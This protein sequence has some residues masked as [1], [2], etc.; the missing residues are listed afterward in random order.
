MK[1]IQFVFVLCCLCVCAT[2]G[3]PRLQQP[4][5]WQPVAVTTVA[6]AVKNFAR[7]AK[8]SPQTDSQFNETNFAFPL[9]PNN[10]DVVHESESEHSGKIYDHKHRMLLA[11]QS[12]VKVRDGVKQQE[13][14]KISATR[15]DDPEARKR[16]K[17]GLKDLL[18][19]LHPTLPVS[20]SGIESES[21]LDRT[22][23]NVNGGLKTQQSK[24]RQRSSAS[25]KT[26]DCE[27][28]PHSEALLNSAILK[29]L[30]DA[31]SLTKPDVMSA[32]SIEGLSDLRR[33]LLKSR[34]NRMKML[35]PFRR[36]PHFSWP[37][38]SPAYN[39]FNL[40]HPY[41]CDCNYFINPVNDIGVPTIEYIW[42]DYDDIG[43]NGADVVEAV[44]NVV[45]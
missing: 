14:S 10:T 17:E 15:N 34:R 20:A 45:K 8:R 28:I 44:K 25:L 36:Y 21:G 24:N 31:Q 9:L 4:T 1:V 35:P 29:E 6:P 12:D 42:E 38:H 33:K 5:K 39:S 16:F 41:N 23:E 30:A 27:D 19:K 11:V 3:A 37:P 32:V 2:F 22:N 13:K 43:E 40:Q 18:S 26:L 7:T